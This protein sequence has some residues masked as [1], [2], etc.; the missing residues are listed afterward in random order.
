[1]KQA[2]I[3]RASVPRELF[4]AVKMAAHDSSKTVSRWLKDVIVRQL[5]SMMPKWQSRAKSEPLHRKL[6]TIALLKTIRTG[7]TSDSAAGRLLNRHRRAAYARYCQRCKHTSAKRL[8]YD[9]WAPD[10]MVPAK[11]SVPA[12]HLTNPLKQALDLHRPGG[13]P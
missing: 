4:D 6:C 8:P 10:N 13:A 7:I 1:M 12:H 2:K 5:G 3:V 9:V 11:G